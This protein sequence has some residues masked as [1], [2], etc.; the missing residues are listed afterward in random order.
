MI[1]LKHTGANMFEHITYEVLP[2]VESKP[3]KVIIPTMDDILPAEKV[4]PT[5]PAL[6][7]TDEEIIERLRLR[8]SV[9]DDMTVAVKKGH[10]RSMI[11]SGPPGVGKSYGVESILGKNKL[12]AEIAT[13]ESLKRY[14]IVKG[15]MT[16]LGL[17]AKLYQYRHDRNVLVF[18]D[19]DSLFFDIIA[20]NLLKAALDSSKTR[21]INWLADS[22][23]L[24]KEDIPNS[25][26]FRGGIIFITNLDFERVSPK[27]KPH[28]E[29]LESRC[30]YLDLTI[31]TEREKMLRIKQI[32]MDGMLDEL[33]LTD[34][35]KDD[36]INYIND[37]KSR[38]RELSLRTVLK[39]AG[40]V[41][42]FPDKWEMMAEM[43]MVKNR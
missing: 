39:T 32:I 1:E 4:K 8:F 22:N 13:D 26:D 7:E 38:L 31:K 36:I 30:H 9:L 12:F 37:N 16:A 27:L 5:L 29:A 34:Y 21:R 10:V 19:C 43:T 17:Y 40:L 18:D 2:M 6:I 14:D 33:S 28:V 42:S 20:M 23:M 24:R 41:A 3:R 35:Q 15:S 25:F 11:V